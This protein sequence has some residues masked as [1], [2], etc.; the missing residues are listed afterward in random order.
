MWKATDISSER[1]THIEVME[2]TN[3]MLVKLNN[4]GIKVCAIVTDSAAA[5]AASRYFFF[6]FI[7]FIII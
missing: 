5:Y 4:Q 6:L 7:I 3:N 1:E 2:K